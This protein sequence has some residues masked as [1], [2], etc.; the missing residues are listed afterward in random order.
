MY[1]HVFVPDFKHHSF[2]FNVH[3]LKKGKGNFK[4]FFQTKFCGFV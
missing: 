1:I 3:A 2:F 4:D